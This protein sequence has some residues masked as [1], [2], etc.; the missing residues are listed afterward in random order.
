VQVVYG[1][2]NLK[3]HA[4]VS[5]V[6]RQEGEELRSYAHYG[7]GNYHPITARIYTDLSFFTSEPALTHD[8]SLL[9]NYIT[10][11]AKPD[12]MAKLIYSPDMMQP[13]LLALI[14]AEIAHAEAGRS[15]AIWAKLNSLVDP[16][17]IEALY[18]ASN[19]G[20]EIELV[21]RG[22][23]CLR[24][25][26]PG[27]SERITVKSIVG[28]FLEHARIVC[29]GAGFGLPSVKA[30]VYISSAD[31]MPRNLYRRV[32]TLVP[33]E[34]ETVRR[35]IIDQIMIAN[36]KDNAQSWQLNADG[37]YT[38]EETCGEPFSAH[39]YF[40]HNPSLSGRGS[41]LNASETPDLTL[42]DADL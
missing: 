38:K 34:N 25:G 37:S 32:E 5:L 24:P 7:T 6:V 22:I 13:K 1:F 11:Y 28:R 26:V 18:R 40:M 39:A 14:D 41:A 20:V 23:C 19:A 4:K 31:W 33:I 35:Q 10:G 12:G 15:A 17:I 36:L 16:K 9:F 21:I 30:A 29:F 27:L 8:A 42:E 3:T 2:M